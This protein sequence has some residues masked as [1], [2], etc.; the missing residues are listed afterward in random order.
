MVRLN[1][2]LIHEGKMSRPIVHSIEVE[3]PAVLPV[4]PQQGVRMEDVP[5]KPGTLLGLCF[6]CL[7]FLFA[8]I[9]LIVMITTDFRTIPAFWLAYFL[10]V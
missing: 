1:F 5:G 2:W 7:Q 3:D 9:T 8:A 6:R 4:G 10:I